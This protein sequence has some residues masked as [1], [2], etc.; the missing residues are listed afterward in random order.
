[1]S[2]QEQVKS[3]LFEFSFRRGFRSVAVWVCAFGSVRSYLEGEFSQTWYLYLGGCVALSFVY[4][5]A[6]FAKRFRQ[7]KIS[8]EVARVYY[9]EKQAEDR[10]A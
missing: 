8:P 10:A 4:Q 9:M 3:I 2:T 7:P 1:M 6:F 5:L